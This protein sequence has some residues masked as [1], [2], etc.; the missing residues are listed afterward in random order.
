ML[1]AVVPIDGRAPA[2]ESFFG[3]A[4][5]S[6]R[7]DRAGVAERRIR[8]TEGQAKVRVADPVV[9]GAGSG[10][11]G[12]AGRRGEGRNF[13]EVNRHASEHAEVLVEVPAYGGIELE[14]PL[15]GVDGSLDRLDLGEPL[16]VIALLRF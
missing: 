16:R 1:E 10:G 13:N 14:K 7:G 5:R 8:R 15:V 6:P 3:V 4:G 11:G 12:C 2:A 9:G